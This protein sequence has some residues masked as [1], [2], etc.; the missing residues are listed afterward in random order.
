MKWKLQIEMKLL[1]K[2]GIRI[3][4]ELFFR[5]E[6]TLVAKSNRETVR[7]RAVVQR[8]RRSNRRDECGCVE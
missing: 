7:S 2:N 5:M 1:R 3:E 8:Q 6:I 4:I